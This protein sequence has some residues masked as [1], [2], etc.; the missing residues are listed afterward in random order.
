MT[1]V[2]WQLSLDAEP[3]LGWT[4]N[5][6]H[7]LGGGASDKLE[8][9]RSQAGQSRARTSALGRRSPSRKGCQGREGTGLWSLL[10][11]LFMNSEL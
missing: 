3:L 9:P 1:P 8:E 6:D 5:K 11:V 10:S 2:A 4:V 7:F